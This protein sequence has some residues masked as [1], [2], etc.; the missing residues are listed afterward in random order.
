MK[1]CSQCGSP[2]QDDAIFCENCGTRLKSNPVN[3]ES[4][5]DIVKPESVE[6]AIKPTGNRIFSLKCPQCGANMTADAKNETFVCEYCGHKV[7]NAPEKVNVTHSGVVLLKQD[8]SNEPNLIITFTTSNPSVNMVTRIVATGE[9]SV[10]VN[11]TTTSF[12]LAPGVHDVILKIGSKNYK[13]TVTI[14]QDNTPVKISAGFARRAFIN[15]DQPLISEAPIRINENGQVIGGVGNQM[16]MQR[17]APAP[18][19]PHSPMSI[20]AFVC[21]LTMFLAPLAVILAIVDLVLAQKKKEEQRHVFSFIAL[22][23]GALFTIGLIN[24]LFNQ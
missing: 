9:K 15:I 11:G 17:V 19:K 16:V 22:G 21:A 13:R 10:Y 1:Y 18:S 2:V 24:Y 8:R 5:A 14:P 12:H 4:V 6:P 23:I 7:V 3:R 20:V